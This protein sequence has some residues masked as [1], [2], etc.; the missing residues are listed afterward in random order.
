MRL[1]KLTE[2]LLVACA[3]GIPKLASAAPPGFPSSGNGLWYTEP[4]VI[5]KSTQ[6]NIESLWSGGPFADP[7]YNGGNKQPDEQAAMA[8]AMQTIRQNIFESSDGTINNVTV[9]TTDAGAYGS[10][11]GAGYLISTLTS[12]ASSDVSDYG[13]FLDLDNGLTKAIWTQAGET[14][15]RES[16]C[17]VPAEACVQ[18]TSTTSSSGF[19]QTYTFSTVDGL[20]TPNITCAD[21]ATLRLTGLVATPGMAYEILAEVKTS[22]GTVL[23]QDFTNPDNSANATITAANTTSAY[24]LWVGGTNYDIDAGDAAHNFSF[25][26]SDPHATLTALLAAASSK[27]YADLLSEHQAD[28]SAI[29][30]DNSARG[31]LPANLQGKWAA[32]YASAW[33]SDYHADIN[34]QMNYWAA[35]STNLNV[36]QSLFNYIEK[37]W[38]PRGEYTARVLYNISQGWVTHDEIFGHTGMKADGNSAQWADYPESNA[39]LMLHV[40]DH[41]DFTNDIAWWKE[42][43]YPLL[44]GVALFHMNKLIPDLHFNDGTLVVAPCNSPEQVP[45]TLACSHAQQLIWQLFNAVEKVLRHLKTMMAQMDK[46]IH[47]EW[48]VDLDSPTDTHRHL[49]HLVGLYPGYAVANYQPSLQGNYTV[50]EVLNAAQ[51]SLIHRGNGTGP[52]ADAGWEKVW[53][54]ACWAQFGMRYAIQRNFAENLFDIYEP[55]DPIFQIEA[56]LGYP[57]AVMNA[58]IQSPAVANT[59]T[60]LIITLLPALPPTWP[61]GTISGA[62]VRSGITA[63]LSWADSTPTKAVL[64]VDEG[65]ASRPVQVVYAGEVIKSFMTSGGSML[66]ITDF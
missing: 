40:W 8:E 51:T 23:C 12:P 3:L 26:G 24:I 60:P 36:T 27:S 55:S 39:W 46:G 50:S 57:A 64:T 58:L 65:V 47:I 48:K 59:T 18:N 54:A 6:L 41:F 44:K 29:L 1:S 53:R 38:A 56:N 9:L 19:T 10:Y 11:S 30:H 13:R 61:D 22:G 52:D 2:S 45:I 37:T 66:T 14:L 62:R 28:Y 33:G 15:V 5:W 42:Q 7:S 35:E 20:P 16:F 21:N 25:Q 17:S 49:S 31:T 63:D 43:G 34:V 4:G 32:E